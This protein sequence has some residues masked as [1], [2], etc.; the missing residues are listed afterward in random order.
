MKLHRVLKNIKLTLK[1]KLYASLWEMTI[2]VSIGKLKLNF[3]I[4]EFPNFLI[5]NQFSILPF[6]FKN[7]EILSQLPF[8]HQ[9]P[10][11]RMLIAQAISENIPI[12]SHDSKFDL[13]DVVII[14]AIK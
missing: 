8:Y 10:F 4:A 3:S 5:Q 12:I 9:D 7:Y 13:Y 2:K 1:T 14:D 11:D 6:D